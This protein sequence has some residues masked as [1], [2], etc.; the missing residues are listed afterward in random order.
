MCRL[1]GFRANEETKV[2]CS[3]VHAQNALL[4]QSRADLRGR[5]HPHGWGLAF[6]HNAHPT[7]VRRATAAFEDL[8]FS[9]TVERIY[10]RAVVA[11]IRYATVG[12][13]AP[14]NSHPFSSGAWTFAHNGTVSEFVKLKS[15]MPIAPHLLPSKHG[16]TD[17]EHT[18]FWLLTRLYADGSA[19]E[20]GCVDLQRMAAEVSASITWLANA[21]GQLDADDPA[22]L[23]FILTDGRSLVASR[24]GNSLHYVKRDGLHDCEICGIPHVHHNPGVDYHAVVIASEPVS[25]TEEWHELPDQSILTVDTDLHV[26]MQPIARSGRVTQSMV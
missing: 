13:P 10:T 12:E 3:L 21:C 25:H 22:T 14:E 2:E 19:T 20:A 4:L 23:N 17:S 7:V 6:Y 1:Y 18:F 5:A 24:W 16:T 15:R 8:H 9:E 11:H 26:E